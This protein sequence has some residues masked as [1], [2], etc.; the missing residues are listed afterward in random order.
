MVLVLA[1]ARGLFAFTATISLYY[2]YFH[3]AAHETTGSFHNGVVYAIWLPVWGLTLYD[4]VRSNWRIGVVTNQPP[5][6][7][8]LARTMDV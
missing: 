3:F 1:P 2:L 8:L 6:P 4:L 5:A 7:Q